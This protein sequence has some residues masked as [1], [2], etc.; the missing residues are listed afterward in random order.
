M[1][2]DQRPAMADGWRRLE[3]G[4]DPDIGSA[5]WFGILMVI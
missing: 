5:V 1:P 2:N 3:I 4:G